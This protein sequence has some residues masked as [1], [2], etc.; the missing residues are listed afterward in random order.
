MSSMETGMDRARLACLT[1]LF[2][3]AALHASGAT[4]EVDLANGR[5]FCGRAHMNQ[6]TLPNLSWAPSS[7]GGTSVYQSGFDPTTW[8]G[9]LK[10]IMLVHDAEGGPLRLAAKAD[11][12]AGEVLTGTAAKAADPMPGAR[13]IFITSTHGSGNKPFGTVEFKWDALS[14]DQKTLFNASPADGRGDGLGERRLD[15]LRGL[16]NLELGRT[17]GIFRPR[18]RVLGD[19]IN[20]KPVYVGA[21]S[22]GVQGSGYQEFYDDHKARIAAVYVGAN[23][24]MLHGFD[25][26]SG[27]ELFAYIA[28]PLMPRMNQ[29]TAPGYVHR[30]YVDGEIGIGE[31]RLGG[32]WRT[33]LAAG[34]GGGAQGVFALDVSNPLDFGGGMG[35]V[36][37]FTDRDDAD[38]GNLINAPVVA[39]FKTRTVAGVAEYKYFIVV[40]GGLNNYR[41]DG[42]GRFDASAS[43]ALFL[44]SLDK[45]AGDRWKQGVNYYKFKVPISEPD[46]QGGLSA[47]A[48]VVDGD[49]AVRYAYAGDLQ[50]NLWCFDFTGSAPW[51]AAL[52]RSP[53][54]P[55]FTAEDDNGMRQPITMQPKVVFA[56][57]GGYVVLFGTGKFIEPADAVLADFKGQSFYGI[58][59]STRDADK[60]SGRQQLASRRSAT[61]TADPGAPLTIIGDAFG[62]GAAEG[63]KRGWYFDFVESARTGERGVSDAVVDHGQLFFNSM[64]PAADPCATGS[65]RSYRLDALTGL[66]PEDNATGFLSRAG[67]MG[68]PLLLETT[69][70]QV[71]ERNTI[72]KRAVKRTQTVFNFRGASGGAKGQG[73]GAVVEIGVPAGRIS[74]RE[75]LNWQELRDAAKKE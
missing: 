9:S 48:L 17:G 69:A 53:G 26:T 31:A 49:G 1:I 37:E 36:L 64:I 47:P 63:S 24:G 20:S 61:D 73:Q 28:A 5:L 22:A 40:P 66:P 38:I 72:G 70:V 43:G 12:D 35:V 46:R 18:E 45:A 27:R 58:Y 7:A 10:K 16:R 8:S 59:D 14:A 71:G 57:G 33:I 4:P 19:I 74:W 41:N 25:A 39:K 60:I 56:P 67:A 15:Y 65:S 3:T 29:L 34:M 2:G 23:D 55:L 50:G 52:G 11:W 13:Y 68:S 32:E 62:Y 6:N 54:T 51:R 44:L 42:A 75:I 30:P 21:P